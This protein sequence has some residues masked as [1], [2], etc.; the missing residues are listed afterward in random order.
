VAGIAALPGTREQIALIA[1][2]R[3]NLF[4]NSLR[5]LKGRLEAVSIAFVWIM[6]SGLILGGGAAMGIVSYVLVREGQEKWF[7]LLLWIV[8][9]YW[10]FSPLLAASVSVQFDFTNLL[11]FP[12][13]FGSFFV[14]SVAYGLFDAGAVGS[15][16]WLFCMSIGVGVARPE[17][18]PWSFLVLLLFAA[19][20]LFLA[21][22][23]LTWLDRWLAQRKT[24]EILGFLFVIAILGVQFIGPAIRHFQS[25]H[26]AQWV[27]WIPDL[28]VVAHILPPEFAASALTAGLGGHVASSVSSLAFLAFYALIFLWLL[29]LR[30]VAQYRGELISETPAARPAK[31]RPGAK[32]AGSSWQIPL[33]SSGSGA[34]F[35]KEVRYSL[36]AWVLILNLLAP[37]ILVIFLGITFRQNAKDLT[38]ILRHA[39]Y[40]FPAAVA[41][42]FLVQMNWV[43]NSFA[44]EGSGIQFLFFAPVKFS[45]VI[46]GKNLFHGAVALVDALVVWACVAWLFVPPSIPIVL[47]TFAAL[48]FEMLG[49][50][51]VG[52][53]LS[54]CFPRRMDFAAFRRKQQPGVTV[55]V[56]LVT[57]MILIGLTGVV[58]F[59]TILTDHVRLAAP[60]FLLLSA[61][62]AAGY[63][64]SLKRMDKLAVDHRET[65]T[66][67]LCRAE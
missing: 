16:F 7:L 26:A 42:V 56:G 60:I 58:F 24:R 3:W 46:I 23:A 27:K 5:T 4:R 15:I 20:N 18:F 1:R 6:M 9:L 53:I 47:A 35:E 14:L 45:E 44:Y 32:S 57:E 37:P 49:N 59:F 39:E 65:L 2:L 29:Y 64:F 41:Y 10:Q 11:R 50:L 38:N 55:A 51:A 61:A 28:L 19:M 25:Q 31:I 12:L 43:F 13:R 8:F 67:E 30:L 33:V 17:I 66:A 34:V 36:R 48:L 54:V 40:I 62:T 52:N 22:A 21:R 63:A